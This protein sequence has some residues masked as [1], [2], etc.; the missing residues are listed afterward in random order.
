MQKKFNVEGMSCSAC[1]ASVERAVSRIEGVTSASVDLLSKTLVCDFD[2]KK[3]TVDTI[4]NAVSKAGFSAQLREEKKEEVKK[5]TVKE[6]F[7]Y[8]P[9]YTIVRF[10]GAYALSS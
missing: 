2:E 7:T 1:S 4:I 10:H 8:F 9:F 3:V 5:E 6:D